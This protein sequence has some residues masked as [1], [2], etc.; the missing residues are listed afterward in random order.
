[1]REQQE[2]E[3]GRQVCTQSGFGAFSVERAVT[4]ESLKQED[5]QVRQVGRS[6]VT[7]GEMGRWQEA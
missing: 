4:G 6:W 3:L 2:M 1:M 5:G 7:G